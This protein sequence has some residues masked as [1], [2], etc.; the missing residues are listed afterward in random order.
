MI[1]CNITANYHKERA[2]MTNSCRILCRD[3]PLNS[4]LSCFT[5]EVNSSEKAIEIVQK[6]SDEHPQKTYRDDF[7]EKFP[8]ASTHRNGAPVTCRNV[9]YGFGLR[10]CRSGGRCFDCWNEV[11]PEET[12]GDNNDR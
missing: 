2:R 4:T 5:F 9:V 6:W 3:C 7:L 10:E 1:D 8:N 11:M 12:K